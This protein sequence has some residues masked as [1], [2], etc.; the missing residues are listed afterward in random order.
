MKTLVIVESPA[1]A[2][3]IKK[4]L[5][6]NC[7]VEASMGH[8][9]DLPKEQMGVDIENNFKPRYIPLSDKKE[10]LKKLKETAQKSE[11]VVLATDPD[12]EGEAISWHIANYLG[13]DINDNDRV[14]FHEITK[15]AVAK[16]FENK[17]KINMNL[18]NSQQARRILDRLVGYKLSPFLWNKIKKGLSAGRVQSVATRIIVDREQEIND[19]IP[20]EYWLIAAILKKTD[21]NKSFEAKFYGIDNKKKEISSKEEADDILSRIKGHDFIVDDIK[22]GTKQRNAPFA[23]TTSTLQQEANK[24]LG[25]TTKKTMMIAQQ[26]Y[27]GID[28][29]DKGYT[30]LI[31]YLRTDSVRI[32]EEAKDECLKYIC[33]TYGKEYA[34]YARKAAAKKA[35]V[36]DAHEAIRPTSV[37]LSPQSIEDSLNK[38]QLK[39]YELIYKR[40]LASNMKPAVYDVL[41]VNILCN[42]VTF[43]ATGSVITFEGYLKA[44]NN[45]TEEDE[46]NLL[47]SLSKNEYLNLV[48]LKNEQKFTTPPPRYNEASLV[49]VLEEKGI[50]RPSTYATTI[51]TI[52]N[53]GYVS[54]EDKKF[55]P[56]DLGVLV[57]NLMKENFTDIIDYDFTAQMESNL[58]KIAEGDEEWIKVIRTFYDS[59][60]KELSKAQNIEKIKIP[61]VISGIKCDKCGSNMLIKEGRYGKFLACQSFPNCKNIKPL[62]EEINAQCPKCGESLVKKKTKKGKIFY[63]CSKYPACDFST[64]DIPTKEVCKTCGSLKFKKSRTKNAQ[65]YCLKC[66]SEN[67]EQ[68][69]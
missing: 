51:G 39:L 69:K 8:V 14:E 47:P 28:I 55:F 9:I 22:Q 7:T 18:V 24:K 5:P 48:E 37:L 42:D 32:S 40:F 25:F 53:R 3:T 65:A 44:Y 15:N 57:T 66:D 52:Q 17:R 11:K 46:D 23:F 2:K 21:D 34:M 63:G 20:Q 64:W 49:K 31:T 68:I 60:E 59:F 29:N 12:R 33:D 19:F 4:Y 50:G 1:K 54:L 26:L 41:T 38:D 43:R 36:Q 13:L 45:K 58:D 67:L 61:D 6:E 56:T 27:E 62:L 16:A 10:I 35:N 30:G